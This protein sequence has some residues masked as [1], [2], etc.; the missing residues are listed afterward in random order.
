MTILGST[1]EDRV[2][3]EMAQPS[4][5]VR[6]EQEKSRQAQAKQAGQQLQQSHTS[7]ADQRGRRAAP[8]RRPLFRT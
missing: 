7:A 5:T 1:T 2:S 6:P 3:A 8:G 4:V